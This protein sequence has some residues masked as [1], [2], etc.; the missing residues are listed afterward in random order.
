MMKIQIKETNLFVRSLAIF[1]LALVV[2]STLSPNSVAEA[3]GK[4]NR[5]A[6]FG[7]VI[8]APVDGTVGVITRTGAL[9]ITITDDTKIVTKNN[10]LEL[11]D[12]SPGDSI[13][14][15]YT[16]SDGLLIAGK[17][18]FLAADSPITIEHILGVVIDITDDT[19]TVQTNNGEEVEIPTPGTPADDGIQEGS[20][21]VAAIEENSET[22]ELD[23]MALA[24]AARTVERLNDAIG[25]EISLAQQKLLKIRMS[26][27]AS[28]HLT[29]LY[30]TLDSIKLESQAKINAAFAEFEQNYK[31][32]FD[33]ADL[34]SLRVVIT[35]RV[36]TKTKNQIVVAANGNGRRSYIV[37]PD[38]VEV[39]LID[40]TQGTYNDVPPDVYVEISAIPQTTTTSPIAR[41]I[42]IVPTPNNG[43]GNSGPQKEKI[44]GTIIVVDNP[45]N[46]SQKVIVIGNGGGSDKAAVITSDTTISGDGTLEEGQEVEVILGEDG[47]SAEQVDV[48]TDPTD[49]AAG[50]DE[51]LPTATPAPPMR[52][53][54]A[55]K[56][57]ELSSTGVILDDVYLVL[58]TSSPATGPLS[59]GQRI[60]FTVVVDDNGNWTIVGIEP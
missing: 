24:T 18:T 3:K 35:G 53:S 12:V 47:I 59:V 44:K 14:G 40:G 8:H 15:Y 19:I 23:V 57:R 13:T 60:E 1:I 31:K 28:A 4:D 55:G 6:V 10:G 20:L 33:P 37:I 5:I 39:Q 51:T 48:I 32:S 52:F 29:R 58:D 56:I 11:A 45:G 2:L 49:D 54:L 50:D 34:E 17:L 43:N 36:L 25:N 41:L 30:A 22:G 26:A 9:T 38:G 27:T 46:G 16:E 7:T 42:K 21:I